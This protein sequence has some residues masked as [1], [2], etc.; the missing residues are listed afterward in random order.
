MGQSATLYRISTQDFSKVIDNPDDFALFKIK[1]S[2]ETFEKTHEGLRFVL[3]KGQE[4]NAAELVGQVF[5]PK[6]F[7]GEKI[8]Y[9]KLEFDNLP[10]D[11]DLLKEPIYYNEPTVVSAIS[12]LLDNI[13]IDHF[14]KSFDSDELNEEG[15]YPYRV[16]NT[17]TEPDYAFNVN[18][19]KKEF[20]RLKEFYKLASED[21]DYILSYVG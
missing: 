9:S 8:D 1:K 6:A 2:Y 11:I 17:R 12:T 4:E 20:L 3:S 13:T 5:Y 15:I 14:Q 16:W 7:V 21:R 18:D 10:D 19:M